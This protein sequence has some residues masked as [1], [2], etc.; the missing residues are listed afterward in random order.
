MAWQTDNEYGCHGTTYSYSPA[1]LTLFREWL[2]DKYGLSWQTSPVE[3]DEL[4]QGDAKAVARFALGQC[5]PNFF[6]NKWH[7]RM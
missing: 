6:G 1:A 2:K 4:L 7:I 5:L 3:M